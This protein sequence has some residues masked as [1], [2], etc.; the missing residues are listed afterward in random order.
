MPPAKAPQG[1]GPVPKRVPTVQGR[2]AWMRVNLL[3]V[4]QDSSLRSSP[5]GAP[6]D[7]GV[8]GTPLRGPQS[9]FGWIPAGVYPRASGGGNERILCAADK[10]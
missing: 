9:D 5:R 4:P 3:G 7:A 6:R 1:L 10:N 2:P 8:A